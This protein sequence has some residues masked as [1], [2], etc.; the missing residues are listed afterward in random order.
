MKRRFTAP[1]DT[2]AWF[3]HLGHET[4]AACVLRALQWQREAVVARSEKLARYAEFCESEAERM[5]FQAEGW[6][7]DT[8]LREN[9]HGSVFPGVSP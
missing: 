9:Q 8:T 7:N 5:R 3:T 2:T 4:A 1:D 6:A